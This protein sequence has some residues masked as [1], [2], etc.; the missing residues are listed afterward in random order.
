MRRRLRRPS[1]VSLPAPQK[2]YMVWS[3]VHASGTNSGAHYANHSAYKNLS[4]MDA[5]TSST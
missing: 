1:R 3:R 5:S 2:A 4:L